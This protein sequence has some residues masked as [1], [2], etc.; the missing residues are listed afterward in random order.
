MQN[1]LVHYLAATADPSVPAPVSAEDDYSQ[2][3]PGFAGFVA[4]ALMVVVVVFL[5]VDMTRRIRRIRYQ[6]EQQLRQ[7]ELAEL[8]EQEAAERQALG[9]VAPAVDPATVEKPEPGA[10]GESGGR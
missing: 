2:I 3:G 10:S 4:T 1:L 9:E 8:G 7:Q 6:S 5:I